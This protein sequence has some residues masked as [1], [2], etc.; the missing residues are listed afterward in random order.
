MTKKPRKFSVALLLDG[1]GGARELSDEEVAAWTPGDG[2]LWVDLNLTSKPGR[3]WL[4]KE[5]GVSL[6]ATSTAHQ[7]FQAGISLFPD[8]DN[9]SIVKF[10]EQIAGTEVRW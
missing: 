8:E 9:W 2:I 10:L 3:Q 7:L 4:A 1:K 6:F 5:S